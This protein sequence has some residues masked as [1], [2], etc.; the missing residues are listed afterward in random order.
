[1]PP[2][3]GDLPAQ[4]AV[5]IAGALERMGGHADL[6]ERVLEQY[7]ENIAGLPDE[8]DKLLTSGDMV[9][10]ARTLHTIKGLSATV[11]ASYLAAVARQA[12]AAVKVAD[13][14]FD[15][16][17]LRAQF[18]NAVQVT[19]RVLGVIALGI[20]SPSSMASPVEA[21]PLNQAQLH[22]DLAVLQN[23]LTRFDMSAVAV[24]AQIL[25]SHGT[26]LGD[27]LTGLNDTIR[28]LDFP[29]AVVEC[30]KLKEWFG[31][32]DKPAS[33]SVSTD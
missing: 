14:D 6:F 18:R 4:D 8:L 16:T 7:M 22:E 29:K 13:A 27:A 25:K 20:G 5:D 3:S 32:A 11:G 23:L 33:S 21:R 19:T 2:A 30:E 28:V 12:E 17:A 1:M 24:H 9:G 15:S 31:A 10:A 26:S